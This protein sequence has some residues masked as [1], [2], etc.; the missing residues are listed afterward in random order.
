MLPSLKTQEDQDYLWN[1]LDDIDI[2][3]SDHAPHTHEE[4]QAGAHG[5]PGLET[6]LGLLLRAEKEGKITREQIIDKCFTRP[7]QI[8]GLP[9]SD[10]TY[11][12]VLFEDYVLEN[13]SLH[14]KVK[15]SPFAGHTLTGKVVAT[16]INGTKVFENGTILVNPGS[17]TVISRRGA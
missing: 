14:T 15:W 9:T 2:F 3:E 12:E 16:Y 17:G 4:K 5:V 10:D 7:S 8:F 13:E 11:I 1:H 6:T